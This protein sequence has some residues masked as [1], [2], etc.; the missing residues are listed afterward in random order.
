MFN[1][2]TDECE[3]DNGGCQHICVNTIGSYYCLCLPGY[4]LHEDGHTCVRSEYVYMYIFNN[5]EL[6]VCVSIDTAHVQVHAEIIVL[7]YSI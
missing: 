2:D 5:S 4:T 1:S 6:I 7:Y 3:S